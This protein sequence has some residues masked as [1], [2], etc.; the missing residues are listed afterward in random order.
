MQE[1]FAINR[2]RE[3]FIL[4]EQDNFQI[5]RVLRMRTGDHIIVTY[6][7]KKYDCEVCFDKGLAVNIIKELAVNNELECKV[8]LIYGI[9]KKDKFELVIQ[10]SCELGVSFIVPFLAKR[11]IPVLDDK[12]TSKKL[13][14]WNKIAK[15]AS[16]QSKRNKLVKVEKAIDVSNVITTQECST[17]YSDVI[18]VKSTG[19][20]TFFHYRGANAKFSNED[21]DV[22]NLHCNLFHLGYLKELS[23]VLL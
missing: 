9:P 11:S 17:S 13:E 16:E 7:S 2:I 15:E 20:R 8:T 5:E 23:K 10:K 22:D 14:R 4:S 3:K 12:N 21:I 18:T 19:E 1:Y 6:E